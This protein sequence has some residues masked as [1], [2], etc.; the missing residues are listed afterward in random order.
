MT[1]DYEDIQPFLPQIVRDVREIMENEKFIRYPKGLQD[2]YGGVSRQ[3][4]WRLWNKKDFPRVKLDGVEGVY[5]SELKK[6]E[7]A[8]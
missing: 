6:W 3:T 8:L 1:L 5:L 7:N 2:H 4:V